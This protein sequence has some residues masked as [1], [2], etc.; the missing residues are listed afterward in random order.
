MHLVI[1]FKKNSIFDFRKQY[2]EIVLNK[3][4]NKKSR[5]SRSGNDSNQI[6]HFSKLGSLPFYLLCMCALNDAYVGSTLGF[7][8]EPS[9]EH[10]AQTHIY[11]QT[12]RLS[13]GHVHTKHMHV[14][15]TG[16]IPS[17]VC[18]DTHHVRVHITM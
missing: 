8:A 7:E 13:T 1:C 3:Q 5:F 14:L 2:R 17:R 16:I 18:N 12:H 4:T 9:F 15:H 6:P 11:T 10:L